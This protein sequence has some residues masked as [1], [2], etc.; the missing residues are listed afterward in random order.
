MKVPVKVEVDLDTKQFDVSVGIP[1]SS[2]LLVKELGISKGSGTPN[3]EKV[4]DLSL[5]NLIRVAGFKREQLFSKTLKASIK[6]L[7]GTC[8]SMGIT[9]NGKEPKEVQ[10]EIDEG[11]YDEFFKE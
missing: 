9:V 4:G 1:T 6:E 5:Q 11:L 10:R 8:V 2:A 7:L 3:T